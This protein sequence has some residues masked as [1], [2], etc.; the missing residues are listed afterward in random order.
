MKSA[1]V[2]PDHWSENFRAAPS[3]AS[4]SFTPREDSSPSARWVSK[5]A[6]TGASTAPVIWEPASCI[7]APAFAKLPKVWLSASSLDTSAPTLE[8]TP[9]MGPERRST[10]FMTRD[11]LKIDSR[12][13]PFPP[14]SWREYFAD[15]SGENVLF[16]LLDD[17]G[18]CHIVQKLADVANL[19]R[20]KIL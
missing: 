10:R 20:V 5:V 15:C 2:V 9:A 11:S 17:P 12:L 8:A 16:H 19:F 4:R 1:F 6:S 14:P 13:T 18:L 7:T 3:S